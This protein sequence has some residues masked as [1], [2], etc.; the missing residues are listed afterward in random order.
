MMYNERLSA[1][2]TE[3]QS[4]AGFFTFPNTSRSIVMTS[5]TDYDLI[6]WEAEIRRV[7][8]QAR[9][10]LES[11]DVISASKRESL[12]NNLNRDFWKR[13]IGR[14]SRQS[15]KKVYLEALA[16]M[17]DFDKAADDHN[18][19]ILA[20]FIRAKHNQ[21]EE[22]LQGCNDLMDSCVEIK[23]I[24]INNIMAKFPYNSWASALGSRFLTAD[25][26]SF[27]D[28]VIS[29][30]RLLPADARDRN[31]FLKPRLCSI[32]K[33]AKGGKAYLLCCLSCSKF[34]H[35]YEL[36]LQTL[37]VATY[38]EIIVCP[39][40]DASLQ[41]ALDYVKST[42]RFVCPKCNR[43]T[44][45]TDQKHS[46]AWFCDGCYW[47]LQY[48]DDSGK[49]VVDRKRKFFFENNDQR[50]V[51]ID[52]KIEE[53]ATSFFKYLKQL[54]EKRKAEKRLYLLKKAEEMRFADG[55]EKPKVTKV[56][57]RFLENILLK[58]VVTLSFNGTWE[59]QKV[60]CDEYIV[61][62]YC[63]FALGNGRGPGL[64]IELDGHEH[65]EDPK[66]FTDQVRDAHLN[67]VGYRVLRL[68]NE[69]AERPYKDGALNEI[70]RLT[71]AAIVDAWLL[72]QLD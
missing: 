38:D 57:Q 12:F 41:L 53:L 35:L 37:T 17:A 5:L 64:V 69:R 9:R 60:L 61:D 43:I 42:G 39:T 22:A 44:N 16:V 70:E 18:D 56:E 31:D 48:K 8:R 65:N 34:Y 67:A 66:L 29:K 7:K 36:S 59:H 30:L 23:D 62:F 20:E 51:P 47:D 58:S 2:E 45:K 6:F 25:E 21:I 13:A 19:R 50:F 4:R 33:I 52:D 49:L 68:W 71:L 40:C 15:Q 54:P 11:G 72:A 55:Q 26:R 46:S 1:G 27:H 32:E 28:K 14:T 3:V 63:E 24:Q 10:W